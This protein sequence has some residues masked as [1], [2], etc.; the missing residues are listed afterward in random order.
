MADNYTGV[1]VVEVKQE[2]IAQLYQAKFIS[3]TF[4]QRYKFSQNEYVVLKDQSMDSNRCE[5]VITRCVGDRLIQV[6]DK[7]K[8]VASN[9][10][11]KNKEQHMALDALLDDS[12][13]VVVLTGKAG[14]GKTLMGLAAAL[15]K[16]DNRK[17]DKI[18]LTR[19][20]SWVGKH[21]LGAL[22]GDVEDKFKPYLQNYMCNIEHLINGRRNSID[23][24][25][26]HYRM[27]FIPLQLIRGASW[28]NAFIIADEVQVL[29]YMEM[30]TL[31]T[32]VGENSKIVILGD[33]DQRD[34]KI[35]KEKTGIH[36]FI[37]DPRARN[38]HLVA[39][40]ELLKCVRS[41]VAKLFSD[42]FGR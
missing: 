37:N 6:K 1:R 3:T 32:R 23:H 35:T 27:E 34:E 29:D 42:V 11:A 16:M 13:S 5:S 24:L 17:Y 10:E 41:P 4:D 30:V 40:L 25:I 21:G 36:K 8:L 14:S 38:S 28:S 33:L 2:L 22:P 18:I 9:V 31:G 39:S 19:P 12:I 20:M 7:Y 15:Q 26:G